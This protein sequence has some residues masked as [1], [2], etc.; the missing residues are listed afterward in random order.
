[1]LEALYL[2]KQTS[3]APRYDAR[4]VAEKICEINN[5]TLIKGSATPDISS[6]YKAEVKNN[7]ITLENRFNNSN[8]AKVTIVDMREE[9]YR[10]SRSIF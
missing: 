9:F 5:A 8:L 3:P 4:L 10:E 6:Y 1:M 7:L 2:H